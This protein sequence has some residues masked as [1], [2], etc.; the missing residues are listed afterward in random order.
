MFESWGQTETGQAFLRFAGRTLN[1]VDAATSSPAMEMIIRSTPVGELAATAL[2]TVMDAVN[3]ALDNAGLQDSEA[4]RIVQETREIASQEPGLVGRT[5]ANVSDTLS[6]VA[7]ST[8]AGAMEAY[9]A[10]QS[11][12]AT[13]AI[14]LG[15]SLATAEAMTPQQQMAYWRREA[16]LDEMENSN[17]S[18]EAYRDIVNEYGGL[19]EGPQSFSRLMQS[20]NDVTHAL[21]ETTDGSRTV[22]EAS[23]REI[24][25][26]IKSRLEAEASVYEEN[27]GVEI[28]VDRI[29]NDSTVPDTIPD[30]MSPEALE[31]PVLREVLSETNGA[32]PED[33]YS[34]ANAYSSA[35][36]A[37]GAMDET[38]PESL[39]LNA[40]ASLENGLSRANRAGLYGDEGVALE[41]ALRSSRGQSYGAGSEV[42]GQGY[43]ARFQRFVRNIRQGREIS[44]QQNS[45]P[46]EMEMQERGIQR[47]QP[48]RLEGDEEEE[49]TQAYVDR[50]M[51][52]M[53]TE[54][55]GRSE[56]L[57]DISREEEREEGE[58]SEERAARLAPDNVARNVAENVQRAT[59]A[60]YVP[61]DA[62]IFPSAAQVYEGTLA[63][64]GF[65]LG[66]ASV[67]MAFEN[68]TTESKVESTLGL[69][70]GLGSMMYPALGA[71]GA[72][73]SVF[74]A[75]PNF[76]EEIE[77]KDVEGGFETAGMTALGVAA[78]VDPWFAPFAI[79]AGAIE[80]ISNAI[81][82]HKRKKRARRHRN[83]A[84]AQAKAEK[85]AWIKTAEADIPQPTRRA[86]DLYPTSQT[87]PF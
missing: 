84:I 77:H 64:G 75:M 76:V 25:Q 45:L 63:A 35:A 54:G 73:V 5:F 12:L 46:A 41:G 78:V 71:V 9:G 19:G 40:L 4:A 83:E 14:N 31:N 69:G 43:I 58:S 16:M 7:E 11:V 82:A 24:Q 3:D 66:A 10:F 49:D 65:A 55:M 37:I 21:S 68:G 61:E 23:L 39:N 30:E 50:E 53:Q 85:S 22:D 57:L 26:N 80:M 51:A 60:G 34:F 87:R 20:Y 1:A 56:R 29:V 42:E 70:F 86:G 74:T 8:S 18:V 44:R 47:L 15:L 27:T 32:F 38:D 52:R 2:N 28:N 79:G 48:L 6:S 33:Y 72:A 81:L 62:S 13:M 36:N 59:D 17:H 67:G